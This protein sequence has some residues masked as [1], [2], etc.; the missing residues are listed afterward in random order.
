MNPLQWL[1]E[2]FS[3]RGQ[4][5]RLYRAG[6]KKAHEHDVVGAILD[7]TA[8]LALPAAPQDLRAMALFNRGLV[9]VAAGDHG[10]GGDDLQEVAAMATTSENIRTL[11]RQKLAR[12]E[13]RRQ[14]REA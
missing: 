2:L 4:A 9:L 6:M 13:T 10:R 11:A 3:R 1:G 14:Q 8:L 5:L 12:M 7:Y